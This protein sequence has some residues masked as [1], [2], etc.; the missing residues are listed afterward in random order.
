MSSNGEAIILPDGA[1]KAS[2]S[3]T[4]GSGCI[5]LKAEGGAVLIKHSTRHELG[6]IAFTPHEL[7]AFI[8]GARDGEFDHLADFSAF[9]E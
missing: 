9:A 7:A 2:Y 5:A 8:L 6:A 4:N 1:V 3:G